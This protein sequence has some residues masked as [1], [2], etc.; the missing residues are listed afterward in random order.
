MLIFVE[1]AAE[2]VAS[3]DVEPVGFQNLEIGSAAVLSRSPASGQLHMHR[4]TVPS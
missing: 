1:D 4:A 2:A 3:T